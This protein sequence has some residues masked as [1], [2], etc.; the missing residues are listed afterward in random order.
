MSLL[1]FR[2]FLI[3]I[4]G[5]LLYNFGDFHYTK[6]THNYDDVARETLEYTADLG[7]SLLYRFYVDTN[8]L[9]WN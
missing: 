7:A 2:G 9:Q 5:N 3:T 1:Q 6:N 8:S 4:V